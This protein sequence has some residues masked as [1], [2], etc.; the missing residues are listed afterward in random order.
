MDLE[1][2]TPG[3]PLKYTGGDAYLAARSV[4]PGFND[5]GVGAGAADV[6]QVLHAAGVPGIRYLD[7][8]SRGAGEGSSNTVVFSP[9][10]MN[11]IRRYGLAGLMAGGGAAAG[12][13][14]T[15]G[16]NTQ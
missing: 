14:Q 1:Y 6:S 13:Q 15:G 9:E 12:M 10:I 7:A 3:D 2:T 5:P 11:I 16:D 8:G 4:M